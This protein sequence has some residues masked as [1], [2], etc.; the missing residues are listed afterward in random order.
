MKTKAD[1][2]AKMQALAQASQKLDGNCSSSNT[3]SSRLAWREGPESNAK[4]D[5]DVVDSRP[6]EEERQK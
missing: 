3:L 2:E 6:V 1:I 5:D 4:D